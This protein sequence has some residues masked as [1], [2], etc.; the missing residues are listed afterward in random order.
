VRSAII[1]GEHSLFNSIRGLTLAAFAVGLLWLEHRRSLRRV[2]DSKLKRDVRNLAVAGLAAVVV[3]LIEVPVA[4]AI[5]RANAEKHSGLLQN[6]ATP[7]W[8]KTAAAILLLDYTLYI[9]HR[10][11]HR[12]PL[13]WRFHRVHHIDREMDASTALRFHFGE[14]TISVAFRAIQIRLIGA[15]P[16]MYMSWQTILIL[17][18]LFHHSNVRLPLSWERRLAMVLVTPRLH[19]IHHSVAVEEVNSNWS[20]GLT[21]WDWL[22]GTLRT[23][24]AQDS[25][26]IGVPG[27]RGD[28]DQELGNLLV[29]PF[30]Y[31]ADVPGFQ[32]RRIREAPRYLED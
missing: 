26:V 16:E 8:S 25:I 20:S 32:S 3:K 27:F 11:T 21:I 2:G 5:A 14:I 9:W 15:S 28:R 29:H 7:D 19:A 1:I 18:I 12:V 24:V 30:V 13:L 22:H 6:I 31:P 23:R 10:L 17:C 4:L